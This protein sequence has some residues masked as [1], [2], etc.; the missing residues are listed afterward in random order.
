[1]EEQKQKEKEIKKKKKLRCNFCNKK[2]KM[3]H[4]DCKCG[5]KFCEKHRLIQMHNCKNYN[6]YIKEKKDILKLNNPKIELKKLISC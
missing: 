5:G 3:I 4:Y 2:L 6:E 1:M